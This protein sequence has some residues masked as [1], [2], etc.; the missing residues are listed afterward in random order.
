[1]S[2]L[3]GEV[4]A[5]AV[6][7]VLRVAGEVAVLGFEAGDAGGSEDAGGEEAV[8]QVGDAAWPR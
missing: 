6:V 7:A 2:E 8:D 3:A 1:M 4:L 5:L